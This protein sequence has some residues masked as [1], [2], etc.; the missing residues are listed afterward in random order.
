MEQL[1]RF[2]DKTAATFS[3]I[4]TATIPGESI[5]YVLIA[6]RHKGKW[7]FC[8]HASRQSWEL[9]GGKRER[10]ESARQA[11]ERELREETGAERFGLIPVT[12]YSIIK[13]DVRHGMLYMAEVTTLNNALHHEIA[14][15]KLSDS[16][17]SK[18]RFPDIQPGLFAIAQNFVCLDNLLL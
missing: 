1:S 3:I 15:V 2:S 18:L 11:A 5:R 6:A 9:P 13:S 12:A 10:G 8:R 14:E 16:L 7:L 17:P 4:D